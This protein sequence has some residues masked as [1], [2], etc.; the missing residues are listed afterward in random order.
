MEVIRLNVGG[1]VFT[2]LKSTLEKADKGSLLNKLSGNQDDWHWKGVIQGCDEFDVFIDRD[3][4][5]FRRILNFLRGE[6][7][8]S[9]STCS[10]AELKELGQEC[11]FYKLA[12][13]SF[14]IMNIKQSNTPQKSG[15]LRLRR[16]KSARGYESSKKDDSPPKAKGNSHNS[17]RNFKAKVHMHDSGRS[18]G[19]S[20]DISHTIHIEESFLLEKRKGINCLGAVMGPA[21]RWFAKC[22][23]N[24][25]GITVND[26]ANFL[27]LLNLLNFL[28]LL[29]VIAL[30]L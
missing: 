5:H 7:E 25:P 19:K 4:S 20:S 26:W 22:L 27:N 1:Q 2:T 12:E 30:F 16:A 29:N 6:G 13:L 11:T 18:F 8:A 9:L 15:S 28:N 10:A 3:P 23:D 21:V 17:G 24:T 14:H